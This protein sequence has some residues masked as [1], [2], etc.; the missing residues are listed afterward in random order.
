MLNLISRS[1]NKE[2]TIDNHLTF[3]L[4]KKYAVNYSAKIKDTPNGYLYY[5]DI[6]ELSLHDWI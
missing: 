4:D 5:K 3:V 6:L 1:S 2:I